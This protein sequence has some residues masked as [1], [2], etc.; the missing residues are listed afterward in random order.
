LAIIIDRSRWLRH[1]VAEIVVDA[2]YASRHTDWPPTTAARATTRA[3]AHLAI[4]NA[5]LRALATAWAA[6]STTGSWAGPT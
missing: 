4:L 6:T 2:G 3:S 1:K 5:C